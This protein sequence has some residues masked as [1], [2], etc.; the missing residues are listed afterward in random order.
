MEW[1]EVVEQQYSIPYFLYPISY[2]L[3][4]KNEHHE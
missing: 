1:K 3:M 2:A 4:R